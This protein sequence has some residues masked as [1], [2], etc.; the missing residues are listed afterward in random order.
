M[1]V[2]GDERNAF[3]HPAKR[4]DKKD[5]GGNVTRGDANSLTS[6]SLL[7]TNRAKY[8][9]KLATV[10][11]LAT[12]LRTVLTNCSLSGDALPNACQ[13]HE[14]LSLCTK[15]EAPAVSACQHTPEVS[16]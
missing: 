14:H 12:L 7:F 1:V 8:T 5:A 16:E 11:A 9:P 4:E 10:G 6:H 13:W 15:E 2:C 3:C